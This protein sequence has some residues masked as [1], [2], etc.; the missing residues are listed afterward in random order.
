MRALV[1]DEDRDQIPIG[2]DTLKALGIDPA[3]ALERGIQ[4]GEIR[5]HVDMKEEAIQ[6]EM[7]SQRNAILTRGDIKGLCEE[8]EEKEGSDDDCIRRK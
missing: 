2:N 8:T 3:A 7:I 6:E 1:Q 5:T 4:S